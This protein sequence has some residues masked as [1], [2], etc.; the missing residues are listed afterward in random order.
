VRGGVQAKAGARASLSVDLLGTQKEKHGVRTNFYGLRLARCFR[1]EPVLA[2]VP[3]MAF[4]LQLHDTR[5]IFQFS[6]YVRA[7]LPYLRVNVGP[8]EKENCR[9]ERE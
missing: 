1:L 2:H 5:L 3:A 8:Q 4:L 9:V 7:F 6:C